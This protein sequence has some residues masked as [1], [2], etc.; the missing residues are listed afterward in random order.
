VD[1]VARANILAATSDADDEVFNIASGT[2][3]SLADL[4]ATLLEAMGS[5]LQPEHGPER[6]VNAVA[7]RLADT[8][9]AK[10]ALGFE[11]EVDLGQ[12]LHRLVEWWQSER[13]SMA[14]GA[15]R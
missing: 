13:R 14:I 12:G 4:A 9:R 3:T 11:A 8:R 15:P 5:D 1:D 6:K 10:D 7:R 2:E